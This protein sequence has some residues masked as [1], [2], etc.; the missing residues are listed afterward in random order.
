MRLG[1][2][3]GSGVTTAA[4]SQRMSALQLQILLHLSTPGQ[5]SS[6]GGIAK[7]F[8]VSDATASDSI[9]VLA[10]KG[11]VVK[12]RRPGDARGVEVGITER[13]REVVARIQIPSVKL[14]D[15]VAGWDQGRHA[16]VL[17]AVLE[18]IDSLQRDGE[19]YV[20]RICP[21]CKFFAINCETDGQ[22]APYLC[23]HFQASLRTVDLR[24]DCAE[25][26]PLA[27]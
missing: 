8:Q 26:K 22:S 17:P 1:E 16:E 7:R 27:D 5:T 23:N 24:V 15:V 13:A 2:L 9:R 6:V 18:L 11:L 19:G 21:G 25:F 12:S 20:D 14:M 3:L 4:V 10:A